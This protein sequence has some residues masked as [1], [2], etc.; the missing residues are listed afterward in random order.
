MTSSLAGKPSMNGEQ[1]D[2]VQP[3]HAREAG[4]S[5]AVSWAKQRARPPAVEVARA[6]RSA[7]ACRRGD[8][9]RPAEH[10]QRPVAHAAH[11]HPPHLRRRGRAGSSSVNERRHAAQHGG[12]E[13][14]R[15]RQ[16]EQARS[17]RPPRSARSAPPRG[18]A[19]AKTPCTGT[20][21]AG[22][23]RVHGA[24]AVGQHGDQPLA[25]RVDDAAAG[26]AAGV[27]AKAHAHG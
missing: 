3:E 23:A 15:G 2:P 5:A 25:R 13:Q 17:P 7:H 4:S 20:P 11:D 21:A 18:A 12:G 14:P 9:R 1:D 22:T 19:R 6:A 24:N 27:A 26:H 16:R 8:R 10:E